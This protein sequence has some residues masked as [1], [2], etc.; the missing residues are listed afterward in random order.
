M[1]IAEID[2]RIDEVRTDCPS[3]TEFKPIKENLD[4]KLADVRVNYEDAMALLGAGN[5][6]G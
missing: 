2:D 1:L 5:F 3:V 6:G 4:R